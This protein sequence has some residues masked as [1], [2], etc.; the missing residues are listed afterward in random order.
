[1]WRDEAHLKLIVKRVGPIEARNWTKKCYLSKI[2]VSWII[3]FNQNNQMTE[4]ET[5]NLEAPA[6][7]SSIEQTTTLKK[8]LSIELDMEVVSEEKSERLSTV[9]SSPSKQASSPKLKPETKPN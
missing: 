2:R 3:N 9:S 7:P 4:V 8:Q 5:N 6:S 1:M